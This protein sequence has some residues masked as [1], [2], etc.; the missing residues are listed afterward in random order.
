MLP[1]LAEREDS[2]EGYMN[3]SRNLL[4]VLFEAIPQ[5]GISAPRDEDPVEL[6]PTRL[7]ISPKSEER[8]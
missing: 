5:K 8:H 7:W 1:L 4:P 6:R 2:P 3:V